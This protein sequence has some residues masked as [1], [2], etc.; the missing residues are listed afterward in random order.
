MLERQL[1]THNSLI[2]LYNKPG[3][4]L[5]TSA[6]SRLTFKRREVVSNILYPGASVHLE[7]NTCSYTWCFSLPSSQ[8]TS[9]SYFC[10]RGRSITSVTR[11]A[12]R[13]R[14]TQEYSLAGNFS[15]FASQSQSSKSHGLHGLSGSINQAIEEAFRDHRRDSDI[16]SC[17]EL[18]FSPREA[19]REV[20]LE[21]QL[22]F[23]ICTQVPSVRFKCIEDPYFVAAKRRG[24]K[25]IK[26]KEK[27]A[28]VSF[29]FLFNVPVCLS[30]FFLL[31]LQKKT[32]ERSSSWRFIP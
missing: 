17:L 20:S 25:S 26:S 27:N 24:G 7:G 18:P 9:T 19:S 4:Q 23:L 30:H 16:T 13:G 5:Y 10:L 14:D 21:A 1:H 12:S 6:T 2:L 22:L 28:V 11:E 32:T 31:G 8:L 3:R 15:S 29:F